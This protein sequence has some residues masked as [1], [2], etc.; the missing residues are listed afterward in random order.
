MLVHF[1]MPDSIVAYVRLV[2]QRQGEAKEIVI[3]K[4]EMRGSFR[5][6]LKR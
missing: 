2:E 1:D 3:I 4:S 5:Q 6:G